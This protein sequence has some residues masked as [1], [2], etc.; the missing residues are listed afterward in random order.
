MSLSAQKKEYGLMK[1]FAN[2]A[3]EHLA[4]LPLL[5]ITPSERPPYARYMCQDFKKAF[6]D[7]HSQFMYDTLIVAISYFLSN[8]DIVVSS[9]RQLRALL[10]Y[11]FSIKNKSSQF[12]F[13]KQHIT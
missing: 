2:R 11:A 6:P 1:E 7:F 13:L 4:S 8:V 5:D 12:C 9:T 3:H 10:W